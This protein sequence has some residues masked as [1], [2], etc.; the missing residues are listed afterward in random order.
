M[1]VIGVIVALISVAVFVRSECSFL[2][3]T[4]AVTACT[5]KLYL[6]KQR[7]SNKKPKCSQVWMLSLFL[8]ML[9]EI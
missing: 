9:Y 8:R 2:Y 7:N 5:T 6:R 3:S 4:K 1:F